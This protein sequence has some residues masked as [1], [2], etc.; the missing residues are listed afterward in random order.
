[1]SISPCAISRLNPLSPLIFYLGYFRHRPHPI[2]DIA[3]RLLLSSS[4]W[5]K[6]VI[7]EGLHNYALWLTRLPIVLPLSASPA[8]RLIE[9]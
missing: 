2:A 6:F 7:K 8:L 3:A 1:M 9:V 4:A 5:G